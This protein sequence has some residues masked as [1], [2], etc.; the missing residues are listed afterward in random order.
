LDEVEW[1]SI[2][3]QLKR[4]ANHLNEGIRDRGG[5]GALGDRP[6]ARR[7]IPATRLQDPGEVLDC[8]AQRIILKRDITHSGT[9]DESRINALAQPIGK[10]LEGPRCGGR[11]QPPIDGLMQQLADGVL[12]CCHTTLQRATN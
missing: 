3:L 7:N 11:A 12:S 6:A 1:C 9:I 8:S 4:S 2:T 5:A 10:F